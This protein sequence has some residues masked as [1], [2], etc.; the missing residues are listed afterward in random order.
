MT[1]PHPQHGPNGLPLQPQAGSRSSTGGEPLPP[2]IEEP[3]CE[4]DR[5]IAPMVWCGLRPCTADGL[6][7]VGWAPGL[8][9][10]FIATGHARMGMT[11]GPITGKLIEEWM[12]EGKPSIDIGA[13]DPARF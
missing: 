5:R 11:L 1:S 9:N 7:A 12:L 2:Q 6:P 4:L 8:K 3:L 10:V 13:M